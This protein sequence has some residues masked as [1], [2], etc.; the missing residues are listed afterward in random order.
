VA[1]YEKVRSMKE[2]KDSRVQAERYLQTP[3]P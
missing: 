1:Q 2:Y 3:Y